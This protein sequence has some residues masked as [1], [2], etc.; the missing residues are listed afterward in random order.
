MEDKQT[1]SSEQPTESTTDEETGTL[2]EI[3]ELDS[4]IE[5]L[6]QKQ[7]SELRHRYLNGQSEIETLIQKQFS[8]LRHQYLN[9]RSNSINWWFSTIGILF[10][11]AGFGI[12]IVS[13]SVYENLKSRGEQ[14]ISEA[15]KHALEMIRTD[16]TEVRE[17][18]SI[19]TSEYVDS[20]ANTETLQKTVQEVQ[21][22]PGSSLED[23]IIAECLELQSIGSI[24]EAY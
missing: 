18:L 6:I 9:D 24:A 19:V 7:L 2:D 21:Q 12:S 16:Q 1:K 23:K 22:N 8:E 4:K 10:V 5:T 11:V 13:F 20:P 3:T 14:L 17:I 15:E